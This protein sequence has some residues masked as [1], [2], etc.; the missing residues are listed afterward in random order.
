MLVQKFT[1]TMQKINVNKKIKK[2]DVVTTLASVDSLTTNDFLVDLLPG[3]EKLLT[4]AWLGGFRDEL[5]NSHIWKWTDGS[6]WSFQNWGK[7][8]PSNTL[9]KEHSLEINYKEKGKWND[10]RGYKYEKGSIC[11]YVPF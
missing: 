11:Q 1:G 6:N 3:G 7:G 9:R 4:R 8:Q 2:K 5:G 10:L